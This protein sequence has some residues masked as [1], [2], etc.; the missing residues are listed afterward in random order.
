[1]ERDYFTH[2]MKRLMTSGYLKQCYPTEVI[3]LPFN[4]HL[5]IYEDLFFLVVAMGWQSY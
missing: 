4:G 1:M 2:K 3:Q 5:I